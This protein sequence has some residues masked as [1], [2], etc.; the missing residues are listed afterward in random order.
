MQKIHI[1]LEELYNISPFLQGIMDLAFDESCI[2]DKNGYILHCS[3]SSPMI[4]GRPNEESI[5]MHIAELD[6]ASPYP[7]LLEKGEA[8][9]GKIHIINGM[10]CITH[11]IPLFDDDDEIIGA[12]GVIIFRGIDKLKNLVR[13]SVIDSQSA[14]IY[15]QLSRA[16]ANYSLSDFIGESP[17]V[18]EA[19]KIAKKAAKY[20]YPVLIRGETGCGKEIL[21]SGIHA[22]SLN[23]NNK[24]FVKINCTAIPHDLLESELFGYE[25]GAFTGAFSTKRG[26]FEI[27]GKG[28]ILLD[29]IGDLN[30]AL[31]SKLLRVVE[32]R[33]YERLGG[34]TLIPLHARIIAS[35]NSDLE[36]LIKKGKFRED[37]YYRLSAIEINAPPLRERKEDIMLLFRHFMLKE[38]LNKPF[39]QGAI[40]IAKN[41]SWPGN[42][43]Q[44]RNV[45]TKLLIMDEAAEV[46][47]EEAITKALNRDYDR[48][49]KAKDITNPELQPS[50][51]MK[52][53]EKKLI[54]EELKN[55]NMCISAAA[56]S[57]G[58]T[59]NTLYRKI[60]KFGISYN[61]QLL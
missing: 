27:A 29:E 12:F 41:Y 16:V 60:K 51:N 8:I 45:I 52:E 58:I 18:K 28:T 31:Q 21:A 61:K 10:T 2:M 7:E 43:R 53:T 50:N 40:E 44:L 25:K 30:P 38:G 23:K 33:E 26:K 22:E 4:W 39:T 37:L 15:N 47:D 42:V 14:D 13:D 48:I 6:S 11:M 5:G 56:R 19:I 55:A 20:D 9:L 36:D 1:K 17:E 35:T 32:E 49:T 54:L 24:P 3:E 34:N 46:I 57:L 59:R